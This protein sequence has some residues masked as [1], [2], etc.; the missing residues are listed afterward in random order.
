M[1]LTDIQCRQAKPSP[2]KKIIKLADGAG[3]YLW[4]MPN[5]KKYWRLSYRFNNKQK[6]LSIGVYPAV[7][8]SEA[9]EQRENA[10]KQLKQGKDPSEAKKEVKR[11]K[12]LIQSNSFQSIATEWLNMKKDSWTSNHAQR[13][14]ISLTTDV[15]PKIGNTPVTEIKAPILLELIRSI[16]SR[17]ANETAARVLQRIKSVINYAIQTGRAEYNPA[18]S[19][20]GVI[21]KVKVQHQPALS[22]GKLIE[23]YRRLEA[24]PMRPVTK[25]GLKLIM[26]TFVRSGELRHAKWSEFD[27]N[28]KEWH[29]P[30]E[31]MKM[32]APHIVPLSDWTLELLEQLREISSYS[33]LLFPATTNHHKPMSENTLSYAMGRM[34]YSGIATPHGFRSLATDVLNENGFDPDVIERQLAHA[35]QNKVRAAYHRTQYLD[36]RHKMMQWYSDWLKQYYQKSQDLIQN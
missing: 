21:K 6:S 32:R 31:R 14:L 36:E 35:E 18:L 25:I 22:Q 24:E 3:L 29:I 26:L 2:E 20:T 28:K 34:G 27:L 11:I 7:N 17:G 4:I 16:E 9:R 30:A 8:L 33:E 5:G 15:F 13:V 23:F 1:A 19:M 10:K 12:K